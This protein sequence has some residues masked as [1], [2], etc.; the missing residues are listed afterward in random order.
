MSSFGD[1]WLH[2]QK[3]P[4]PQCGLLTFSVFPGTCKMIKD[5]GRALLLCCGLEPE[6]RPIT[7]FSRPQ[8]HMW[9]LQHMDSVTPLFFTSPER[10]DMALCSWNKDLARVGL[11]LSGMP[12]TPLLILFLGKIKSAPD[13]EFKQTPPVTPNPAPHCIL[14]SFPLF[15]E[16]HPLPS[17]SSLF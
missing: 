6:Q 14:S 12:P 1:S 9:L 17:L 15:T 3:H 8:E 2:G 7:A 11:R 4:V 10:A 13:L 16:V 5:E